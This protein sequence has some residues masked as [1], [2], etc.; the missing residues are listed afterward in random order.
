MTDTSNQELDAIRASYKETH[1][2]DG[3]RILTGYLGVHLPRSDIRNTIHCI[4]PH[5]NELRLTTIHCRTYHVEGPNFVWH[6]DRNHSL[7]RRWKFI[8][9][10]VMDGYSRSVVFLT[11]STN[12]IAA[13]IFHSFITA[14][15]SYDVTPK[16]FRTDLYGENVDAW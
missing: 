6:V 8:I 7:L 13:T 15:Q 14:T 2:S 5:G 10:G 4:D 16:R 12:N 9:H 11:C 3:E 1:P